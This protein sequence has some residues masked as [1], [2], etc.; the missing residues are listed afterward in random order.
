MA[1]PWPVT[2]SLQVRWRDC[3]GL[4]HVN[5]AV[6]FTYLEEARAAYFARFEDLRRPGEDAFGFIV[7]EARCRYEAP[8]RFRDAIEVS[9][10][11]ARLGT[12]S[13]DMDYEV[14]RV[15]PGG[16]ERVA[17]GQTVQV[18][19]DYAAA[20]AVPIPEAFRERVRL[21]QGSAP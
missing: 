10:R 1:S 9:T 15:S 13:F 7:G 14:H 3:D 8:A 4:G 21:L 5:H 18:T 6:F 16:R 20:R 17:T 11:V 12:K 19:Y 2:V